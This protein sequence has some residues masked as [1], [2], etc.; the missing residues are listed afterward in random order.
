LSRRSSSFGCCVIQPAGTPKQ[1]IGTAKLRLALQ[2]G[3]IHHSGTQPA[4]VNSSSET[5][6]RE[7]PLRFLSLLNYNMVLI[8]FNTKITDLGD[9]PHPYYR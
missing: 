4:T 6:S 5:E 3:M 7:I 1:R 2:E 9:V 8:T